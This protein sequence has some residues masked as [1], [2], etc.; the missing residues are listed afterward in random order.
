MTVTTETRPWQEIAHEVQAIR[1][2]SITKIEPP[3]PPLSESLP[4]RVIDLPRSYLTQ[5]E[6]AITESSAEALVNSLAVG[7]LTSTA[8]TKAFLRRA[9][10][11]Q[12]LTNCIYELLPERALARA[13]ELDDYFATHGKPTG[14]L[15]GLP[16]STKSHIGIE[17][18]DSPAGFVGWVG[19]RK[20]AADA[21]AVK[22]MLEAG[23]VVYARTTE[24]QG[25]LALETC[26]NIT[27]YTVNPHNTALSSGGSSGG[28]SALLALRGSPLGMGADLGGSIR[29]P[30]ANCGLY[31]LKP[32]TGRVPL[33]GLSAYAAGCETIV[34]TIGPLS[35]T[36]WGI[37]SFMK[38]VLGSQPWLGDPSLYPIPWR[39]QESH[40]HRNGKKLTVGVMWSD[41]VVTPTP[42]VTRALKE[43]VARL[44]IAPEVEVIEWKPYQQKEALEILTKLYLPDGGEIFA[45]HLQLSGEPYTPL[46]AWTAR[47]AAGIEKLSHQGLWDWTIKREIF[48]YSYLQE[49]NSIAPD[50]D[51][52]LCPVHP[53]PAP[54]P[55]TSRYWGYT[56]LWNLL[57]YPAMAFPV[58]KLSPERDVKDTSYTPQ[59]DDDRWCYEHYDAAKQ[60]EAP[61]ALQ[62]VAKKLEDEKLV[63]ACKEIKEKIGLPFLQAMDPVSLGVGVLGLAGLFSTCLDVVERFDSWKDSKIESRALAAQFEAQKLR[64]Q[65]WGASV[66]LRDKNSL[67]EH[68]RR[69]DERTIGVVQQILS[70]IRDLCHLHDDDSTSALKSP[71]PTDYKR[72]KD[73]PHSIVPVES[74][75]DRIIWALRNKGPWMARVEQFTV[76]VESLHVLVPP[77]ETRSDQSRTGKATSCDEYS[78]SPA[79]WIT[80]FERILKRMES[81]MEAE[82]RRDLHTWLLGSYSLSSRYDKVIEGRVEGTC[83]W[84]LRRTWFINWF[85][86]DF[87]TERPKTL[88][89]N[90]PA[91]FGKSVLCGKVIDHLSTTTEAPVAY[92]LFSSDFESRRDPFVVIR[93]WASQL[94]S[95]P[96]AFALVRERWKTYHESR[97]TRGDLRCILREIVS[98]IPGCS[99]VLDGL[100]ECSWIG[101]SHEFDEDSMVSFLDTLRQAI[102][103]TT[104]RVLIVSRD[105]P[106]IRQF[107][108]HEFAD[109]TI[110]TQYK[111]RPEDVRSDVELFS[112][113]IVNKR[114]GRKTLPEK[115]GITQ[116]LADRCNGQFL[117]IKLLQSS[118]RGSHSQMW[119]EQ[120]INSTP[121]RLEHTYDRSW[122][123]ILHLSESDR[124]RAFAL[125]RWTAFALRPLT[126]GEITGAL[127]VS[128][129][130][131]GLQID[132]KPDIID[133]YYIDEELLYLCGSLLEIQSPQQYCDAEIRTVHLAHFSVKQYLLSRL[134]TSG[135]VLRHNSKISSEAAQST[136]LAKLCLRYVN[137]SAV[138]LASSHTQGDQILSLFRDYAAG[139]WSQH[140]TVGNPRDSGMLELVY[141]LFDT[142]NP[143][144]TSWKDWLDSSGRIAAQV[145]V[146]GLLTSSTPIFFAAWFGLIDVVKFLVHKRG[147]VVDERGN[148]GQTPLHAAC[149]WGHLD[150]SAELLQN[151]ANITFQTNDGSTPLHRASD[152]GH[153]KIVELLLE[154]GAQL[155]TTNYSGSLPLHL[156]CQN[157][158]I[159]VAKLL[160]DYGADIAATNKS[161]SSPLF[162]AALNGHIE[163]VKLLLQKGANVSFKNEFQ[164]TALHISCHHGY[165]DIVQLLLEHGADITALNNS[166]WTPLNVASREGHPRIVELLLNLGA[167]VSIG[168]VNHWTPLYMASQNGHTEVVRLLLEAGADFSKPTNEGWMPI[169]IA[170]LNGHIDIVDL[171]IKYGSDFNVKNGW[172]MPPIYCASLNGH[173]KLIEQFLKR[174]ADVNATNRGG[175]TLINVASHKGYLDMIK[176]LLAN[177]ADITISNEGQWTP[178]NSAAKK[179]LTEAVELLMEQGADLEIANKDRM[180]PLYTAARNGHLETV[181]CL[182]GHGANIEAMC[183]NG[184]TP[185]NAVCEGGFVEVVKLLLERGADIES[186][187]QAGKTPLYSATLRGHTEIARLLLSHGANINSNSQINGFTPLCAAASDGYPELVK[188]F[189]ESGADVDI[190]NRMGRNPL[191]EATLY[192]RVEVVNILLGFADIEVDALELYGRAALFFAAKEGNCATL[193]ALVSAGAS[194]NIKDRYG[195]T[196][197]FAAVRNGHQEATELL[198]ALTKPAVEFVDG[199]QRN[200]L[201]WAAGSGC[202]EVVDTVRQFLQEA[203]IDV[204]ESVPVPECSLVKFS[205][206]R[207]W[208]GIC[209]RCISGESYHACQTCRLFSVCSQCFGLSAR[210][211]DATHLWDFKK[212]DG[213]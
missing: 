93:S 149:Y 98:A 95:H 168:E 92:F 166:G 49:W 112:Q 45:G 91:G 146:K 16:I 43:V 133:E 131:D 22:I 14:P 139:S 170:S 209:T 84:I 154:R 89:V 155:T 100:D 105:E 193:E 51:V 189:L 27:G 3:L 79:D 96:I 4:S 21:S 194:L 64:F 148:N 57:D 80:E 11:A 188:L 124:D 182:L 20:N 97:A 137:N 138:W 192:N 54:Q 18:R 81:E 9:A 107:L 185:L 127:L 150:I 169:H 35:P 33:L 87:E 172:G 10:L 171:L 32:T 134:P 205:A 145:K 175:W 160:I 78:Q 67:D 177:G 120:T 144:W 161:G 114:L 104:T 129:D 83:E 60:A 126:V 180:T 140:A 74:T 187:C 17:G 73:R 184:Y 30:A 117:W 42:P 101:D 24:P 163:V 26:S 174:G 86:L 44:E 99:L 94:I 109:D 58:T 199:L 88:W 1:D 122:E 39:D 85:S 66:G 183:V 110:F 50:M 119:I 28:E 46:T 23:A 38:T 141:R 77:N 212:I 151:G 48:R 158:R 36:L 197:L 53:V 143:N 142:G 72:S 211:L 108:S 113:D 63:E 102:A 191:H 118:L 202:A 167:D 156:A 136:L 121:T 13:Q 213:K 123:K 165:F 178:L 7:K 201:W 208:C 76:L 103:G 19:N 34:P 153:A 12:K 52:I 176:L 15:H 111:I 61:V 132:R 37:E 125:L 196:P 40:L 70:A 116:R 157:G 147:Y 200:L 186:P 181:K 135:E 195:A 55:H 62:L 128:E 69:L 41:G 152:M 8:V 162:L 207:R 75:R 164:R 68:N 106:E 179:G 206:R 25:L 82:T 115:Q 204:S 65:R 2:E 198:L 71:N 6:L 29:V 31:G 59:N 159:E 5:S 130:D 210:C 47:D 203:A 173:V 56:S 90:G 190:A